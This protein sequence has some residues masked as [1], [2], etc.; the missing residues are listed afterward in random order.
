MCKCVHFPYSSF[1]WGTP[2]L[3]PISAYYEYSSK[4]Q[5]WVSDSVVN[6]ETFGN[7]SKSFILGS[8]VKCIPS[9]WG[10]AILISIVAVNVYTSSSNGWV[11][12]S[13]HILVSMSTVV[14]KNFL[15]ELHVYIIYT[16]LTLLLFLTFSH[17]L[18]QSHNPF[19]NYCFCVWIHMCSYIQD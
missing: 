17:A 2:R 12:P 7:N 5:V 14:L 4:G 10:T 19:F 16:L 1:C 18:S 15:D 6:I 3:F 13:P 9:F 11:F 8:C